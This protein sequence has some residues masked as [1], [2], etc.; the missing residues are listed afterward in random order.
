M[1]KLKFKAI[2]W[3][4]SALAT[5]RTNGF[6]QI[7]NYP[8]NFKFD[9]LLNDYTCGPCLLGILHRFNHQPTI[10]GITASSILVPEVSGGHNQYAYI[11]HFL[12]PYDSDMNF[13]QRIQNF[14]VYHLAMAWVCNLIFVKCWAAN[15]YLSFFSERHFNQIPLTTELLESVL[16]RKLPKSLENIERETKLTLIN[17]EVTVDYPQ[18]LPPNVIQVGG[19]QIR[20]PKVLPTVGFLPFF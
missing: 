6:Q 5:I 16:H 2:F 12:L 20:D 10:V 3:T 11:P 14:I 9:L 18:P 13:Y 8:T 19:L 15:N 4:I 1:C 17:S 7:L